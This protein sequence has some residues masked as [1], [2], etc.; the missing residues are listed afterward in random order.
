KA[1]ATA[2]LNAGAAKVY[3]GVRDPA[4]APSGCVAV[5]LDVISRDDVA[6]AARACGDVTL[7]INNAGNL[8]MQS[9][10]APGAEDGLRREMDV[11]VYGALRMAHAF[12][13]ILARNGGGAIVNMLSVVAWYTAPFNATYCAAKH[14]ALALTESMR[15][16]LKAQGTR[17]LSVFA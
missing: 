16:E 6:A 13:P 17:V 2:L 15:I 4:T 14:A 12:A 1:F 10:M 3:A 11:H 8:M 9:A 5:R 7:L